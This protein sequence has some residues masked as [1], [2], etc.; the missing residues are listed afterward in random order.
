MLDLAK[1]R[2]RMPTSLMRKS[3]FWA[4]VV[5][6]GLGAL[7]LKLFVPA[8]QPVTVGLAVA[9]LLSLTLLMSAGWWERIDE[10]AREAHKSA[11]FWGGNFGLVI[12]GA[13]F[14]AIMAPGGAA[15]LPRMDNPDGAAA[16]YVL[17]GLVIALV[18]QMLG[19]ALAWAGW[20]L[21]KR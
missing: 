12:A 4:I 11:W 20:W 13:L 8:M 19:Y 17:L 16:A 9:G 14:M 10:A 2:P 1:E 18:P 6:F 15:F 21:S 3:A 7:A 5:L